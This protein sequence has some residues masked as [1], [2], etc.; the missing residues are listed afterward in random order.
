[1][2]WRHK[3]GGQATEQSG[4]KE[5]ST[6][7]QEHAAL[8]EQNRLLQAEVIALRQQAHYHRTQ[9]QLCR[10][11]SAMPSERPLPR[12]AP[13]PCPKPLSTPTW[14]SSSWTRWTRAAIGGGFGSL[15]LLARD[16]QF[17]ACC[18]ATP[19]GWLRPSRSAGGICES[20]LSSG[21]RTGYVHPH[22]HEAI[23]NYASL[24]SAMGLSEAEILARLRS[25]IERA[26][27]ESA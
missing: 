17:I 23:N 3:H 25:A 24:L 1:M 13:Q 27:N 18:S 9:H 8:Q 26:P 2:V 19:T 15:G 5:A 20:S 21:H 22:F 11:P 7:R 16:H 14:A 10:F 12:H 6:L 4:E